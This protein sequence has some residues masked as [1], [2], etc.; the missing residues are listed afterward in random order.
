MHAWFKVNKLDNINWSQTETQNKQ[1]KGTLD[2]T[3]KIPT[4]SK[5]KWLDKA[6]HTVI[7]M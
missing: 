3:S 5:K 2:G 4:V 6:T 7:M 1:K